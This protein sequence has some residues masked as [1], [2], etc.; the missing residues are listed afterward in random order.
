MVKIFKA[1]GYNDAPI[2]TL[3]IPVKG[4]PMPQFI[5]HLG[6][7]ITALLALILASMW[8]VAMSLVSTDKF[9]YFNITEQRISAALSA[10]IAI[11]NFP[12][13]LQFPEVLNGSQLTLQYTFDP[14][15][16][17]EAKRLLAEHN[18]DYGVLVA[19]DPTNGHILAMADSTRDNRD[20]LAHANLSITNSYPAA[21]ISKIVTAVAAINE[22]I[23][24]KNTVIPYNGKATS[25]YK[26][27]VFNHTNNKRTRSPTLSESF[28][29]SINTVF[30]RLGAIDIGGDKL[31]DYFDRLGFNRRF[32]SDFLFDN[33]RIEL[34]AN[35]QWQ[36]AES[37]AG[38][39]LRNTLSPL[40]AAVLA[41][42]AVNGGNLVT[43]VVVESIAGPNGIPLYRHNRPVISAV[44][45]ADTANQ[46]NSL[47]QKTIAIG[48]AS[49]SFR[50]FSHNHQA[51]IIVGGKT[52]SL[53]G[54]K[55]KG[56]YD[57]FVGFA[58]LGERK[59][60]YAVLCINKQKW[61]VK[62]HLLGRE[63]LEFYFKPATDVSI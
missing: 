31:V 5:A 57:W 58:E 14:N 49:S 13:T 16:Q 44:M 3:R 50:N 18:P 62:S 32:A 33:G 17:L 36:V 47:M 7:K 10:H 11:S 15:L 56:R 29:K 52:G 28:A 51:D 45:T 41:A 6:F 2:K 42:T 20:N 26:R 34:E 19:M 46:L 27:Q 23:T 63:L 1:I 60:A 43:P 61:Y 21:S 54:F 25:L 12:Q 48:S 39:T 30:G 24:N 37:A 35:D 4:I 53:T 55:P 8:P 40:H 9:N 38:Y 59:V 22:G